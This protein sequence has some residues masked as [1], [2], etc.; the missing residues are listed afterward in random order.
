MPLQGTRRQQPKGHAPLVG[1][2]AWPG[3]S[4]KSKYG[5]RRRPFFKIAVPLTR[6]YPR[7]AVSLDRYRL[8]KRSSSNYSCAGRFLSDCNSSTMFSP[9]IRP[10][11]GTAWR[12]VFS[13]WIGRT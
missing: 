5:S 6:N 1:D 8:D 13:R 9:P 10:G 2:G 4:Q 7:T 11:W 3:F 12:G